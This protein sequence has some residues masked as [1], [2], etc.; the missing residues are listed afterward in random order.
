MHKTIVQYFLQQRIAARSEGSFGRLLPANSG[1]SSLAAL[2]KVESSVLSDS[3]TNMMFVIWNRPVSHKA[4]FSAP[5]MGAWLC[6][7]A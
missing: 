7:K 5:E 2:V 4:C 3:N 1:P 6:M